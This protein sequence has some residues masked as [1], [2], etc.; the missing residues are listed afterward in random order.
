MT[1]SVDKVLI[2]FCTP[3]FSQADYP[4]SRDLTHGFPLLQGAG[5]H[6]CDPPLVLE[7]GRSLQG[8]DLAGVS[9]D[10]SRALQRPARSKVPG[11]G[12]ITPM[13]T[14]AAILV[15]EDDLNLQELIVDLLDC[16]GYQATG[17]GSAEK[18]VELARS[19][20]FQMMISDIRMAGATD[21]LGAVAYIK[22]QLQPHMFVLVM[23]GYA[24]EE[25]PNRAMDADVDGYIYKNEFN[26]KLLLMAVEG[27]LKQ[28]EE[29]SFLRSLF[30]PVLSASRRF[31]QAQEQG[32]FDKAREKLDE[33]RLATYRRYIVA[34]QSRQLLMGSA[35]EIWDIF[36]QLEHH[37]PKLNKPQDMGILYQKYVQVHAL[38][39]QRNVNQVSS[40]KPRESEQVDRKAFQG[41]FDKILGG[42]IQATELQLAETLRHLP[43]SE[44]K[45]N[46]HYSRLFCKIWEGKAA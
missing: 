28:K 12:E 38:I 11:D 15:L 19:Q 20:P 22:R 44:R 31:L 3:V 23:T 41:L 18:A 5:K 46:Q 21:G 13:S 43:A 24:D 32:R 33:G 40:Q 25:A 8:L 6:L 35:L 7:V 27:I 39:S 42:R 14:P 1:L 34:I 30:E 17:A 36:Q 29:R 45:K 2:I 16:E 37:Y 9:L 10:S 26:A 4:P